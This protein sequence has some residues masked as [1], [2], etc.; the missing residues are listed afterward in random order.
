MN[1]P[2]PFLSFYPN[3][4]AHQYD[5]VQHARD[6]K[7]D[8]QQRRTAGGLNYVSPVKFWF[9][10]KDHL[11]Y[12]N[13]AAAS[14]EKRM[15]QE[16][17]SSDF[18]QWMEWQDAGKNIFSFS[19]GLLEMLGHTDVGAVMLM[20]IQLPFD[21]IYIDLSSVDIA[22][23]EGSPEKVE[24]VYVSQI[25]PREHEGQDFKVERCFFFHFV[26]D[27]VGAF[28]E[29]HRELTE[30]QGINNYFLDGSD[31]LTGERWTVEKALAENERGLWFAEDLTPE[32]A[33]RQ[34]EI[35]ALYRSFLDR[36]I[37][38][39]IN[40]LLYLMLP[41][42]EIEQHELRPDL[43]ESLQKRLR[44]ASTKAKQKAVQAEIKSLGFTRVNY[45]GRSITGR[46]DRPEVAG[47][48]LVPHW[49]RG[50]WR[51]QRLGVGLAEQRLTWIRPV[52][53]N[54]QAGEPTKGRVY[55]V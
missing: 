15:A 1:P 29:I 14:V 46:A 7:H 10:D 34:A 47:G 26:G 53:V 45:V 39:V 37:N 27:Y 35:A 21:V 32:N 9:R 22:F 50:H 52:V 8:L 55:D 54:K 28:P 25:D 31:S 4:V 20:D 12:P 5:Y 18:H 42:R 6:W 48:T 43:P 13:R 16:Q 33:G 38:I 3:R 44:N 40:C 2:R 49:R 17:R 30:Y 36:T 23:V 24:G 41:D 51:N 19:R 11:G